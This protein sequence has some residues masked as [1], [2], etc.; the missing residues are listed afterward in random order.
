MEKV[1]FSKFGKTFQEDLAHLVVEDRS[2]SDQMQE[3]LN[4]D[5]FEIFASLC[6]KGFRLPYQI[7]SSPD[8]Q[9]IDLYS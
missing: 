1:D 9:D 5:F 7:W 6:S 2:F 3:L 4:F 8:K